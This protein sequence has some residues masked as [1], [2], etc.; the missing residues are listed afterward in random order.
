MTNINLKTSLVINAP[1]ALVWK[2]LTDPEIVKQYFFGTHQ[3]SDWQVGS[4]ITWTG[5]WEG[6]TYQDHGKIL[7]ITPGSYVKYSYWSTM[8]GTEDKPENYQFV[9]YKLGENERVTTLEISQENVK[10]EAAKEHSESNWQYIFGK[11]K[12]MVEGGEVK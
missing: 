1:A 9:S 3:Q 11:M 4:D 10:D 6:K 5:E 2:A 12:E 8:S 7:E